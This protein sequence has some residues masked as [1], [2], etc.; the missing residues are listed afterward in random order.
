MPPPRPPPTRARVIV[1]TVAGL[2]LLGVLI[3]SVWKRPG[4]EALPETAL[5]SGETMGT[6]FLVKVV[7]P[8]LDGAT[9]E[10]LRDATDAELAAV[11][12]AMSHYVEDSDVS[13]LNRHEADAPLTVG[14]DTAEVLRL[15]QDISER[16]G[17]AFDV[18]VGPL[19][20][21][22]GF[23]RKQ[24]L[25][26]EPETEELAAIRARVG[27]ALLEV[28]PAAPTLRKARADLEVD[29]SAIAKGYGVDRVADALEAL[30]HDHYLVEI[31]GEVRA[32]GVTAA[33]QPWRVGVEQP[34]D[35]RREVRRALGV[36]DAAVATS[37][38]YRSFYVLDGRRVSHTID[39]RSGRPV[40]HALAAVTVIHDRCAAADAWATTLMV[41][42]PDEGP[43]LAYREGLAALF[44]FRDPDGTFREHTTPAFE[45]RILDE[46]EMA[47]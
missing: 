11:N 30:G 47:P 3:Y 18:T 17:G 45:D 25:D 36:R 9:A 44:L 23:H 15:A 20:D 32:R 5:L 24:A 46:E 12:G 38:D 42:G 4:V 43:E 7:V 29:L 33:G 31:G 2:A 26:A 35:D 34:V 28:D 8:A 16:S 1:S 22:W 21:L 6:T 27:Y 40:E 14:E 41:L 19:V 10:A 39:P 13:R 37:G